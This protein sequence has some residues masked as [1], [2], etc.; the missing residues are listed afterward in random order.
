MEDVIDDVGDERVVDRDATRDRIARDKLTASTRPSS[1]LISHLSSAS[2]T[3]SLSVRLLIASN[4]VSTREVMVPK[5]I[6]FRE[7][8]PASMLVRLRVTVPEPEAG[9]SAVTK[10][11]RSI[12]SREEQP[13]N[14]SE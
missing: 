7:V 10:T 8:I 12:D 4:P 11:D 6:C 9:L 2:Q 13:A 1:V 5:R 14:I 3:P